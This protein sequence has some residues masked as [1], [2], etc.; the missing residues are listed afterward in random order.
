VNVVAERL[1]ESQVLLDISTDEQEFE[2]ALDR[3]YRKVV[4]QVRLPGFRPGKAPRRIIEQLL[5]R[6]ILVEQADKDLLDP[7]YQQALEREKL[8]P[9]G[10]PDVEIYQVE[11]LAFKVTVQVYPTIELGDYAAVRVEPRHVEVGDEQ[12]EEALQKL[13]ARQS[14]WEE[15]AE[16]RPIREGD[17]VTLDVEVQEGDREFREPMRDGVFTLG[18]DNLLPQLREALLGMAVGESKD[19]RISF[20]E[21]D[22]QAD[23]EMRGKTLDY[24]VTVKK[25]EEQRLLP[26]DEEFAGTA[27]NGRLATLDALRADLRKELLQGERAKARTEVGGEVVNAMAA[28]ATFDVPTAM[29]D[30]Q[31]DTEVENMR[32]HL[33]ENHSQTL[34]AHLRLENKTEEQLRAEL[35]PEALRR[36]RNS[37]VLREIATREGVSVSAQ[38]VDA[39]IDR[40]VGPGEDA[41]RMRQ[42]YSSNY[43]RNLLET[44]LF[45][46]KLMDRIIEIA[47]EG[48]GAFEP[49]AEPEPAEDQAALTARDEAAADADGEIAAAQAEDS[50]QDATAALAPADGEPAGVLPEDRRVAVGTAEAVAESETVAPPAENP[51]AGQSGA[52]PGEAG[53]G[54]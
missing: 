11:P 18:Q 26:L 50:E 22:E 39:E 30:R 45:E 35:R 49:P 19:V 7:L 44:E 38:D 8:N 42:I 6:E 13:Q 20:A 47:T 15:P 31:V 14:P 1:P 53:K 37:L 40:L 33:Q 16:P 28:A 21:D 29:I 34:Q 23:A 46:R 17:R 25:I 12:V 5:G 3:A 10:E 54:A 51:P 41:Q 36:L 48:R 9:V 4:N 32:T 2:K 52:A 43:V 27:T 24:R